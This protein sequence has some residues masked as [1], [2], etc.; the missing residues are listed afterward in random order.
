MK[1]IT[2]ALALFI[3]ATAPCISA[4][5][6]GAPVM[7]V[8]VYADGRILADG[9]EV[10]L[11]QL[12]EAF[13][14]LSKAHGTVLYYREAP[15][16]EPHPNAMAVV[17]AVVEARLPISLSSKPDFSNVVLPDGTTKPR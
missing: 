8:A 10:S 1:Y 4:A 17:Q 2:L 3:L 14:Q 15:Q 12:R 16:S 5:N 6:G 7:K 9:H 13:A 11:Q